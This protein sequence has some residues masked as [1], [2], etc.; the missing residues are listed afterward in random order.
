MAAIAPAR[1]SDRAA[2]TF[3]SDV[4]EDGFIA[5]AMPTIRRCEGHKPRHRKK[6]P[7]YTL[8]FVACVA[9]PVKATEIREKPAAQVAMDI[10]YNRLRFKKHPLLDKPGCWDEDLVEEM[11][12]VKL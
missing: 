2:E 6:I 3:E 11:A 1:P 10:E 5:A 4:E 7:D 8:P 12:S 9:R